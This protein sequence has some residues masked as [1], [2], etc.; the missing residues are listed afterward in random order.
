MLCLHGP[1]GAAWCRNRV[2]LRLGNAIAPGPFVAKPKCRQQM[3]RLGLRSAIGDID[4]DM[5]FVGTRFRIANF[6]VPI[7]AVVEYTRVQQIEW[8]FLARAA[9]VFLDQTLVGV[10]RMRVL[11]Q[12][13]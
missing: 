7:A 9:R 12:I 4:T 1:L 8:R 13:A 5:D 3:D 6:H 10:G 11:V 2:D